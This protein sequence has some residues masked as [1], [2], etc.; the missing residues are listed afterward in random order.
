M[1]ACWPVLPA[2]CGL[3]GSSSG[4]FGALYRQLDPGECTSCV[5]VS[6]L[7]ISHRCIERNNTQPLFL[8]KAQFQLPSCNTQQ[9]RNPIL[10]SPTFL[11]RFTRRTGSLSRILYLGHFKPTDPPPCSDCRL[12]SFPIFARFFLSFLDRTTKTPKPAINALNVYRSHN[13]RR[14]RHL[15]R[16]HGCP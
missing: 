7:P 11:S 9:Q 5:S 12:R 4:F 1:W 15:Q 10:R 2:S 3:C 8:N 16:E 6:L 14:R 13:G